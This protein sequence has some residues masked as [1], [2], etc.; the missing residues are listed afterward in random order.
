LSKNDEKQYFRYISALTD[1]G[2]RDL[3]PLNYGYEVCRPSH[4]AYAMRTYYLI[5]YVEAGKGELFID[6]KH[7]HIGKGQIFIIPPRNS[8]R[9]IADES[10]PWE[11]VWIG[12]GGERAQKLLGLEPCL[13]AAY[14]PFAIIKRLPDRADTREEMAA[15][16]LYMIFADIFSGADTRPSY[17]RQTVNAI[18]SLYM[19]PITV[20]Q[21]AQNIG[22]DRR[23]LVRIFRA[24]M[25][26][27]VQ[28][29][30]I[31]VR[32]EH[33][34]KL[35]SEGRSVG[36]AAV[37][38]GYNDVFNFSKMFKKYTGQSPKMYADGKI[39]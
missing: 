1:K 19:T 23:Y 24:N 31:R 7:Y 30:L 18:N 37:F 11:Y 38:V 12:F 15:A 26:M 28:E 8:A 9:Y 36:E 39:K 5:H 32:M 20:A 25:G 27:S 22:L 4:E 16:A 35:L 14:E 3:N 21:I 29:Y 13:A 17:V 6:G 10:D 2:Y 33:A 34:K